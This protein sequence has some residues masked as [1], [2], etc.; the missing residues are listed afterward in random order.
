[1]LSMF[2]L[3]V[4]NWRLRVFKTPGGY[5]Q[6]NCVGVC[7][8]LP[9]TFTLFMAKICDFPSSIYELI[10]NL[11]PHIRPDPQISINTLFQTQLINSSLAQTNVNPRENQSMGFLY[12]PIY[13]YGAP[14][15]GALG[16]QS[17]AMTK[18]AKVRYPISDF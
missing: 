2:R 17:S 7:G 11:K 16:R 15:G 13:R 1:M 12:F 9:K 18:L 3:P 6:K 10:K 5:S 14:L 8:W 4:M